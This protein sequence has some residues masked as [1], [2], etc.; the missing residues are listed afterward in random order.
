MTKEIIEPKIIWPYIEGQ[1]YSDHLPTAIKN[2]GGIPIDINYD[3]FLDLRKLDESSVSEYLSISEKSKLSYI[4]MLLAPDGAEANQ[5]R[6][7]IHAISNKILKKKVN[8]FIE[9]NDITGIM[10]PGDFYNYDTHPFHPEPKSRPRYSK[11]LLE[12]AKEKNL[13]LLGVCGG[14]QAISHIEGIKVD[15]VKNMVGER[16]ARRHLLSET[17][18]YD[19][20]TNP[21]FLA[22]NTRAQKAED[23]T[24]IATFIKAFRRQ[25]GYNEESDLY[26]NL[27]EAHGGAVS[28]DKDNLKKIKELGYIVNLYS[29]DGIIQGM[30][31][32]DYDITLF[33]GHPE[34]LVAQ[35]DPKATKLIEH[36]LINPARKRIK[37]FDQMAK[38]Y[39]ETFSSSP[40]HDSDIVELSSKFDKLLQIVAGMLG[41][42]VNLSNANIQDT[43]EVTPSSKPEGKTTKSN[44]SEEVQIKAGEQ[45]KSGPKV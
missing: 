42:N 41:K 34:A 23:G 32:K 16:F 45:D 9:E 12:I 27:P 22:E 39:S 18:A 15:R 44:F 11:I 17:A 24:K 20:N 29:P 35:G 21:N 26:I 25:F 40:E 6:K 28:N 37:D 7:Q 14:M 31:H 19:V 4:K 43:P 2:A 5:T 8:D 13:P 3:D 1:N 30:E 33:Q 10:L 38:E 36:F